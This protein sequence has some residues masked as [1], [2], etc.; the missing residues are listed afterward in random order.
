VVFSGFHAHN[1]ALRV[2]NLQ[3]PYQTTTDKK[4]NPVLYEA[5]YL[6]RYN[7]VYLLKGNRRFGGTC[8]FYL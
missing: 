5:F 2:E 4:I 1:L 6:L 8:R 3:N 7:A